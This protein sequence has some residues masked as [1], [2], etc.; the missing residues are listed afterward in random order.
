MSGGGVVPTRDD[1]WS[2]FWRDTS[3]EARRAYAKAAGLDEDGAEVAAN[4][5]WW[6]HLPDDMREPVRGVLA[7]SLLSHAEI[8]RAAAA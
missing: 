2:L 3:I 6:D 1:Y 4:E 5:V 8:R 7:N